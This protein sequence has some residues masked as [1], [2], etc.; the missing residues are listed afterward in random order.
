MTE[1]TQEL[2]LL[3][4]VIGLYKL[5][6]D[7]CGNFNLISRLLFVYIINETF[8]HS[9]RKQNVYY[10][11]QSLFRYV[12]S[13]SNNH[14]LEEDI[15]FSNEIISKTNK[16]EKSKIAKKLK[17]IMDLVGLQYFSESTVLAKYV[18]YITNI[19]HSPTVFLNWL[20]F[21]N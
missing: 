16:I 21:A 7:I 13:C 8:C 4:F 9:I 18:K 20:V 15:T 5:S 10:G 11:I 12:Q 19:T 3:F 2:L 17:R 14:S 6:K 1:S